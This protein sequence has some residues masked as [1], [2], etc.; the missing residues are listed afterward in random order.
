MTLDHDRRE[1][2]TLLEQV[3]AEC[4]EYRFGQLLLNLAFLVR[5]D[6]DQQLAEL[7]DA[8]LV[9]ATQ[10]YLA[11]WRRSHFGQTRAATEEARLV[12]TPQ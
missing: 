10:R 8:E 4:P 2:L 7:E 5:A 9:A 12:G 6:G 1:L 11:D 3:S